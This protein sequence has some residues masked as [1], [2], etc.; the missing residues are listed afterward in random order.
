MKIAFD[1]HGV[2]AD[3]P[4][5]FKPF[6]KLLKSNGIEVYIISGPSKVEVEAELK[7]I[8]YTSKH[9]DTILSV[10]DYLKSK[11]VP[12]VLKSDGYWTS[13][14]NWWSSKGKMCKEY[15]VDVLFDNSIEYEEFM[16]SNTLFFLFSDKKKKK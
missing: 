13:D 8:G 1:V 4:R 12:M 14:Y 6:L 10:V 5:L 16:P 7:K 11:D 2:I 15:N 3:K 9:F